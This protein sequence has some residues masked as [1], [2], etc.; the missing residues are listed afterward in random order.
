MRTTIL[1]LVM[2][3]ACLAT[4][5][6]PPTAPRLP[7]PMPVPPPP[8]VLTVR[9]KDIAQVQGARENQL[10]GWSL[11]VG[12]NGTG[13]SSETTSEIL[14]DFLERHRR[15][16]DPDDLEAKNVAVVTVT[17]TLPAFARPGTRIDCVVASAGDA[18]TLQG[19]VL[20]QTPLQ[21]ADR[22]V[23][24]VAQGPL[25]IGGFAAG[26][27]AASIQKGHPTVARIPNGALVER[28]V[29]VTLTTD[30]TITICLRE[31]DFTT[32]AR[33]AEGINQ[34]FPG[35]ARTEDTDGT[36]RVTV[37]PQA[38]ERGRLIPFIAS[39]EDVPVRPDTRA[40]VILNERTGTIVA[41]A[42][43]RIGQVAIT[44]GSLVF[45]TKESTD[46]S[47]PLPFSEGETVSSPNTQLEVRERQQRMVVLDEA[48][49]V[50]DVARALNALGA[51]PN[52]I[53][54]IFQAIKHAGALPAE[55]V[56]M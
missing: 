15:A 49:T 5:A 32:A 29:P 52:D 19:G 30:N 4:A 41:G 40:R 35:L 12:L 21:G 50:T 18:S 7:L 43:V 13:D 10:L 34:R 37:P 20:L 8:G 45:I 22:Q 51:T 16:V 27:A 46:V 26:G 56:T 31:P 6:E 53:V 48:L 39:L 14:R 33:L 23:Y 36:I 47:Q 24:A 55:L 54:T 28:A 44:H 3:A 38:R 17:A 11:V 9:L 2:S 25:S 1:L 42:Y